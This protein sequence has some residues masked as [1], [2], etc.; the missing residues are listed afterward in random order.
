MRGDARGGG[1]DS[2]WSGGLFGSGLWAGRAR[3]AAAL[4]WPQS[5]QGPGRQAAAAAWRQAAAALPAQSP[6]LGSAM[7]GYPPGGGCLPPGPVRIWKSGGLFGSGLWAGAHAPGA[8]A[9]VHGFRDD[10]MCRFTSEAVVGFA[11]RGCQR[12]RIGQTET[13][14]VGH[15]ILH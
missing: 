2:A 7:E 10:P 15:I 9:W 12:T 8:M 14:T 1:R 11:T 6:C 3:Q 13:V 5:P 4:G